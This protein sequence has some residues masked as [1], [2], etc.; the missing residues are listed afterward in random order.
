[1][2]KIWNATVVNTLLGFMPP[3][4]DEYAEIP[5][6]YRNELLKAELSYDQQM[7]I[8]V[9]T[10]EDFFGLLWGKASQTLAVSNAWEAIQ[11]NSEQSV[12]RREN[13]TRGELRDELFYITH[14]LEGTPE[15]FSSYGQSRILRLLQNEKFRYTALLTKQERTWINNYIEDLEIALKVAPYVDDDFYTDNKS[16]FSRGLNVENWL[17]Y[18]EPYTKLTALVKERSLVSA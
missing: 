17:K 10:F 7:E 2:N 8:V 11:D 13:S 18:I 1:M 6:V 16:A 5:V 14:A 15:Y 12:V 3:V 4:D 9:K